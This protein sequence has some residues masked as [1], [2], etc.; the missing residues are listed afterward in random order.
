LQ[1][2]PP[3]HQPGLF[4]QLTLMAP[5]RQL[6]TSS[7]RGKTAKK[8]R[9]IH[10]PAPFAIIDVW[11]EHDGDPFGFPPGHPSSLNAILSSPTTRNLIRVFQLQERLK[12]FGKDSEFKATHVHV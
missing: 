2:L 8:V 11:A 5:I 4:Q 3:K 7:A 9:R 12:T 10:Y 6:I 1:K